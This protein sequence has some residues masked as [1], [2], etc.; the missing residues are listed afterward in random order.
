[1][2]IDEILA[3]HGVAILDDY[4]N[5]EWPDVSIGT[6]QY[7]PDMNSRLRPFAISP[8]K[9]YCCRAGYSSFYRERI[10]AGGVLGNPRRS[11]LFDCDVDIYRTP[12]FA[13]PLRIYMREHLRQSRLGPHLLAAK[14]ATTRRKSIAG[15]GP[16]ADPISPSHQGHTP[17]IR[18]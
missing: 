7:L 8:N 3:E 16:Q 11:R 6:A 18:R 10:A 4:F 2:L 14:A 13:P 17:A 15:T 1:M 12:P 9:T 5:P